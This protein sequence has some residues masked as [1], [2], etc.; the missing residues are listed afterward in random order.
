MRITFE[1]DDLHAIAEAVARK[2]T[3]L[4]TK[5]QETTVIPISPATKQVPIKEQEVVRLIKIAGEVIRRNELS[6]ITGLS[7][8]TLW[9]QERDGYF[10]ARIRLTNHSVGW[11][12]SDIEAWLATRPTV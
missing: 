5:M 4:I 10:P 3:P 12:R 6:Q 7:M 2:L 1:A 9:R 8:T 11:R